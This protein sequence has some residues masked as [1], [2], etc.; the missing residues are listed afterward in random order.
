MRAA[1]AA[2]SQRISVHV[3]GKP[4][5]KITHV[6]K[7]TKTSKTAET[8]ATA[9][10]ENAVKNENTVSSKASTTAE[11][12]GTAR[13]TQSAHRSR[14]STA[15]SSRTARHSRQRSSQN[16][17]NRENKARRDSHALDAVAE[18]LSTSLPPASHRRV[19]R[20]RM[21]L[22]DIKLPEGPTNISSRDAANGSSDSADSAQTTQQAQTATSAVSTEEKT[23]STASRKRTASGKKTTKTPAMSSRSSAQADTAH[24]DSAQQSAQQAEH[25]ER[26]TRIATIAA[27]L[28]SDRGVESPAPAQSVQNVSENRV[29]QRRPMVSLLFQAPQLNPA[30]GET[31][32]DENGENTETGETSEQDHDALP[33]RRRRRS[34]S[35]AHR[36]DRRSRDRENEQM[37]AEEEREST[38][39]RRRSR[40]NASERAAAAE[41]RS[42]E[43]DIAREAVRNEALAEDEND[44]DL[45][46]IS[47]E[48]RD[49]SS[50][51]TQRIADRAE[52]RSDER[53]SDETISDDELH[54]GLRIRR[55]R[56]SHAPRRSAV[57]ERTATAAHPIIGTRRQREKAYISKIKD[58]SGSTRLEAKRRR[59]RET[60]RDRTRQS[61]LLEQEA[62]ARQE[63]VD[64]QMVVRERGRH[65]QISV[66]EDNILVEHYVSDID[67]VSTVGNIYVGRVQNVLPGMEAAF[68]N[69]GEARNGVLYAGEVNWDAARLDGKPQCIELAY[70]SGDP[71]MVQVTKDPIGHKGARLTAQITLAGRYIVLVPSGAMTGVSRKLPERERTRL[72]QIVTKL[73]PKSM[74]VIIRTAADGASEEAVQKDFETLLTRWKNV[75]DRY[76]EFKDTHRP[77]I[78]HREPDV[79]IRVVRDIFNDD[80]RRLVVEGDSV[81][82]RIS[83]YLE[84][85]S[86]DQLSKLEKWDPEEHHGAD[87]FD[88]WNIDS[89]LRKGMERKVYLP[90][91]GSLVIDRTEAM[92]TIDVNTG[93][94]VGK[95]KSLEEI[96]TR[97]NLEAAEEI[98]RQLRLR[99]IGGMIMID[100]VDMVMAENR[101]LVLRR[102]IECLSRDRTKHQVAEVTSL[103]LVQMTRKRVGQGLVEAF[104]QECP[105]CHGRGFIIHDEPTIELN[106][107]D[108]YEAKGGDPFE[109]SSDARREVHRTEQYDTAVPKGSS[110]EVRRKLAQIAAAATREEETN[111]A[112]AANAAKSASQ[113]TKSAKTADSAKAANATKSTKKTSRAKKSA[114]VTDES[115]T[116]MTDASD[117]S[118]SST[119]LNLSGEASK[120]HEIAE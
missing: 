20:A 112:N 84:E 21:S 106:A 117:A 28:F 118:N 18:Q 68:V 64:R 78:L 9:K 80:F 60:R 73:T 57:S 74:G 89:Q 32:G 44:E 75:Q 56:R 45:E 14:T 39:R 41:V 62:L 29:T 91:G 110:A 6:T 48:N 26:A 107:A 87:V 59:R 98:V 69:I 85:M 38:P 92:T 16:R 113:S 95:G 53:N 71:I 31:L 19:H 7:K 42:I 52:E 99:D 1:G 10:T 24:A 33:T 17:E 120:E 2:G 83:D 27:E 79:A 43:E 97:V 111:A 5:E 76:N 25:N 96:V 88:E 102:L 101:D 8:A 15:S 23:R 82:R 54:T 12:A 51:A 65:T 49:R 70:H 86:P 55:R 36:S 114:Q 105:T 116:E 66:L 100:F 37:D 115:T 34:R 94:F 61:F 90:S 67:E 93:R 119:S 108:P 4:A 63:H 77:H 30:V 35:H 103:G 3:D 109:K 50:R 13:T 81:Y 47:E 22:D 72:R 40:L 58:V 104:S 46:P 11:T